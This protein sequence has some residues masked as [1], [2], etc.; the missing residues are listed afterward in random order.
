MEH[1]QSETGQYEVK[2]KKLIPILTILMFLMS[3]LALASSP[4]VPS[5]IIGKLTLNGQ[6]L[7]GYTIE[8]KNIR[9]GTTVSGDTIGSLVTEHGGFFVD[10]SKIGFIG[11]SQVY[12][13]D[14]IQV[15]VR[16]F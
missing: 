3:T 7:D 14:T 12:L 15:K 1:K 8:V 2:M 10:L 6:G 13:G 5:P 4:P 16:G 11:P 9:T